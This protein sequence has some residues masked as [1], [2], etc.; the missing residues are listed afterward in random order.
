MINFNKIAAVFIFFTFLSTV[1][2]YDIF[3]EEISDFNTESLESVSESPEDASQSLE[4][5]VKPTESL[6]EASKPVEDVS[7]SLE[8]KIE[9]TESLDS[10]SEEAGDVSEVP[11]SDPASQEAAGVIQ[12]KKPLGVREAEGRVIG[13]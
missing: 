13:E 1:S 11:P 12:E 9:P 2:A 5:V 3:S 7:D 4:S 10:I 8:S 6:N